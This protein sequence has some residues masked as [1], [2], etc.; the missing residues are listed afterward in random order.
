VIISRQ[1]VNSTTLPKWNVLGAL[2][3]LVD[4]GKV[5]PQNIAA[6]FKQDGGISGTAGAR[7]ILTACN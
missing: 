3:A 6:C 1:A 7:D 5:S 2:E 4:W